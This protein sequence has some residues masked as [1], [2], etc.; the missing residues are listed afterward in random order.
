MIAHE[1][2]RTICTSGRILHVLNL[3][4]H[5]LWLYLVSLSMHICSVIYTWRAT[6]TLQMQPCDERENARAWHRQVAIDFFLHRWHSPRSCSSGRTLVFSDLCR[7]RH[8]N[9]IKVHLHIIHICKIGSR[10]KLSMSSSL[11]ADQGGPPCQSSSELSAKED[12]LLCRL[13]TV[14][15]FVCSLSLSSEESSGNRNLYKCSQT[16]WCR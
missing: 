16:W 3:F 2:D 6:K 14:L 1:V 12:T 8:S 10:A 13:R 9:S 15:L 4:G 11:S 7:K 5:V